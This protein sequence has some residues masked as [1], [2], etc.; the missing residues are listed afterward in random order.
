MKKGTRILSLIL[1]VV[2]IFAVVSAV[3]E[4]TVAA[5]R[6][7]IEIK[8]V[9][10]TV[11]QPKAGTKA[12][13][14]NLPEIK[15]PA[16]APYIVEAS[17]WYHEDGTYSEVSDLE[18]YTFQADQT[19]KLWF[20]LKANDGHYF[21]DNIGVT[22]NDAEMVGIPE[23]YTSSTYSAV[24]IDASVKCVKDIPELTSIKQADITVTP[25]K[26]GTS[27]KTKPVIAT[28][29]GAPYEVEACCWNQEDGSHAEVDTLKEYKFVAGKTYTFWVT[30]KAEKGYAFDSSTKLTITNGKQSGSLETYT[31]PD[32]SYSCLV[33]N[34]SVKIEEGQTGKYKLTINKVT[35]K[36][37]A[38]KLKLTVKLTLDG[39]G[40]KGKQVTIEFNKKKYTAKTN[41][42]GVATVT[43]KK[44]ELKKLKVGKKITIKATFEKV[45]AKLKVKVVK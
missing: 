20:T 32:G 37:S 44:A 38:K 29:P 2:M 24:H 25:P 19:Y 15:L 34:V 42:K 7:D 26:A 1:S 36:Q 43:I 30:L 11:T 39:K 21:A 31:S 23:T 28:P 5:A 40:V 3:A 18:G 41:A 27:S 13:K 14:D 45:S 17:C 16:G 4:G 12:T 33:A 9:E 8:E 6:D 22:I 35:V 10:V